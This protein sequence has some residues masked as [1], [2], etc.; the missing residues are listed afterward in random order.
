M[1][2][3]LRLIGCTAGLFLA[4]ASVAHRFSYGVLRPDLLLIATAY[5]AL[6]ADYRAALWCGFGIGLLRDLGSAGPLG[7]SSLLLVPAC[8]ALVLLREHL[9]RDS[10]LTDFVLAGLFILAFSTGEAMLDLVFIRGAGLRLLTG[11][12]LGQTAFSLALAPL[13]FAALGGLGVVDRSAAAGRA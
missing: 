2:R 10:F 13:L 8:A 5:L 12:A 3:R 7:L 6:E 4:Q 1:V 9:M 11:Q